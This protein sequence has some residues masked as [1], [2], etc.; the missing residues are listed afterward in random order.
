M[1]LP[2][3]TQRVCQLIQKITV[4]SLKA[5]LQFYL[6]CKETSQVGFCGWHLQF[7]RQP[8]RHTEA[9]MFLRCHTT[10]TL[11][12]TSFCWHKLKLCETS[13]HTWLEDFDEVYSTIPLSD[14]DV[15]VLMHPAS[16]QHSRGWVNIRSSGK[17]WRTAWWNH[18]TSSERL[19][20]NEVVSCQAGLKFNENADP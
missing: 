12:F 4:S 18:G 5:L 7:I 6:A 3:T 9:L 15:S 13:E 20:L 10:L 2:G 1:L 11:K 17:C 19:E 8:G 14:W 16:W